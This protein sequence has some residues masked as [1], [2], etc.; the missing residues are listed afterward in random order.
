VYPALHARSRPQ[1]PAFI[2][3][4]SG[5]MVTY[6]EL[7]RRS[8][9]LAHFLRASG[10]RRLDHYAIF[11]ENNA[12]Y[13]ECC[14]AGE[15]AGLYYTCVNT[16]LTPDETAYI[17]DNSESKVLIT[18]MAKHDVALKA[19][20]QCPRIERCL[21]PWNSAQ[22]R[23]GG[24]RISRYADRRRMARHRDALFVGHD[25]Q[26]ERHSAAPAENPPGQN[27]PIAD[28]VM[29]AWRFRD[30][31]TYLSP[32]PLYHAAP[33]LGVALT[34][35]MGRIAIIMEHFDPEQ[36]LALVE[37]HRVTHTQ[38]VPTMF[39]RMLKLPEEARR[40]SDLSSQEIGIHAAAP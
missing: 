38:L 8:N 7:E 17:L 13:I 3:A 36:F 18:S 14:C 2:M 26:P 37:R 28:F 23:H 24:E 35:R 39:S 33:W 5:E 9:R 16:Y 40:G 31:M 1:Q 12:R 25:G 20:A 11:M 15:R 21:V 4:T 22:S 30:G 32:A 19:M 34:I 10:V 6:A 29:D 27:L